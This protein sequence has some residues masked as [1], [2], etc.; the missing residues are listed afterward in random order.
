MLLLETKLASVVLDKREICYHRPLSI[1]E[2]FV[3]AAV[4]VL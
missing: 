4:N 1:A 2:A 3:T